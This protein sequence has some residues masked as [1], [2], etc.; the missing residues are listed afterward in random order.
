MA[1]VASSIQL[2]VVLSI[3]TIICHGAELALAG[4]APTILEDLSGLAGQEVSVPCSVDVAT[5][6]DFHSVKWYRESQRV[7]VY[8]EL[9]NLERSEGSLT[10]R[11]R[12]VLSSNETQAGL[13]ISSLHLADEGLY[14][15]EITYL[16]INEGCPVVQY[17]NLTVLAAPEYVEI[18]LEDG[19][20]SAAIRNVSRI[21]PFNEDTIVTLLCRSGGGRPVPR[22]EWWNGSHTLEGELVA[23]QEE[24]GAMTGIN[25]LQVVLTRQD[26]NAQWQCRVNSPALHS[27]LVANLRIDVHVKPANVT[28]TGLDTAVTEGTA[29]V[30]YCVAEGARPAATITWY[31]DSSPLQKSAVET[32]QLQ[33]DGTF[34]TKSRLIFTLN[35]HDHRRYITC[36]AG[37]T[38]TDDLH[39]KPVQ[40]SQLLRVE[41][42]PMVAVSPENVTVNET[43]DVLIFCT[44]DANPVTLTSVQWFKD[45]VEI[46]IDGP[47]KYEGATVDQ[48]ALLLK[49][50][51]RDDAGAYSCRLTN[52]VGTGQS[53]NVA[54]ISVQYPAEVRLT[55]EPELPVNELERPNVTLN[56]QVV[57]GYPPVL[58]G[59]RWYLDGELLKELPDCPVNETITAFSMYDEDLCDVDPSKLLLEYV[60]RSFQGNYSCEGMNAAGWGP[61]SDV[62]TLVI[63]YPPGNT[64]LIF[65]PDVV[66]KDEPMT[67][68][69]GVSDVGQ[70]AV[71]QY[72]WT[73]NGHVIPEISDAQ[74]N[75]SQVTLNYQAN[76]SCTPVN[77]AGEGETATVEVEVYAGPTF[78]ERL[79]PTSGALSDAADATKLSCRVECY[80]LCQIDWFRNGLP[81]RE[82]PMYTIVDSFVP[83]NVKFNQHQSVKS[84]L[85]FNMRMWSQAKLDPIV[86]T[87]NYTCTST[88]NVVGDGVSSTTFFTVEY[89][90]TN[91]VIDRPTIEV[92]EG[93]I[94]GHL[95]CSAS[96]YPLA[97]YYWQYNHQIIGNG[98][99]LALDYGLSR[100]KTGEYSCVAHNQHG[101][102]SAKAFI[103]VVY[104]PEC[105]ITLREMEGKTRLICEVKANPKLVDF[106]WMLNNSTLTTDIVHMG[107]QSILTID[108]PP[109]VSGVYYCY[110]NN[111][112]GLATPC[113]INVEGGLLAKLGDENI[114]IIA[115]IAAAIVVI[116]VVCI[117]LLVICR[118]QRADDKYNPASS[119]E[120]R[121]NP[122]GGSTM[123]LQPGTVIQQ[124]H[125]HKWPLRPGVQVHVNGTNSLTLAAS[126]S[127]LLS[128]GDQQADASSSNKSRSRSDSTGSL[129]NHPRSDKPADCQAVETG[130]PYYET[131]RDTQKRRGGGDSDSGGG[132]QATDSGSE[133]TRSVIC[134]KGP[135]RPRPL[136]PVESQQ[137][138]VT[139]ADRTNTSAAAVSNQESGTSTRKRKKPDGNLPSSSTPAV[140]ATGPSTKSGNDGL[141]ENSKA[142]YEN[143][144]FH[145]LQTA[146]NKD[147]ASRPSSQMSHTPSSGYGSARST[148]RTISEVVSANDSLSATP[149]GPQGRG[150]NSLLNSLHKPKAADAGL[151]FRS[152]RVPRAVPSS[153]P[154]G[155]NSTEFACQPS[156]NAETITLPLHA[157]TSHEENLQHEQ[158][159]LSIPVPAPRFHTLKRHAYQNMPAPLKNSQVQTSQEHQDNADQ[160]MQTNPLINST[161]STSM[162]DPQLQQQAWTPR[163]LAPVHTSTYDPPK[164]QTHHASSPRFPAFTNHASHQ[165][166]GSIVYA[167]LSIARATPLQPNQ[168]EMSPTEYAVLQFMSGGQEVQV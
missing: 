1:S 17:V 91:T 166:T 152:L 167:D 19:R 74:W 95:E 25:R 2:L 44:Y 129:A 136:I 164:Q 5:C 162:T 12:F 63:Y 134:V 57:N 103:N 76:Y 100:D 42:A 101:N 62:E 161:E 7:F 58:L 143:L 48:P 15:C 146:P 82:S 130:N 98:Q 157:V 75:V 165:P 26:L 127:V 70:P 168:N 68:T 85:S 38:V 159:Q 97:N 6:G 83:E 20:T 144:P 156:E 163:P 36:R 47:H 53:E 89:A 114:I 40:A 145:G 90:P 79:P 116:L 107:L 138:L 11:A 115:I 105:S 9:A 106:T 77:E 113:E 109:P 140:A 81:I 13:K 66:V 119:M 158:Q 55:M 65:E 150:R 14:R 21:G 33:A 49:K 46:I 61:S 137:Q 125:Q 39:Q 41:Y 120:Q 52:A 31:N 118:R 69:C 23:T 22:I 50:A 92:E 147:F 132:I 96:S 149:H 151:R 93:S 99:R 133:S 56:C 154:G 73:R 27:P 51:T 153:A 131:L 110:V 24:S 123:T 45:D 142:F 128:P 84:T 122:E 10:N 117:V 28:L 72:R 160:F 112:V 148:N 60:G 80:P 104:K 78:I 86:D 18:L 4:N 29:V 87:A 54:F 135:C 141:P 59:V 94:A 67:L 34:S 124:V 102:S 71:T 3:Q 64:T 32:T 8:S 155:N 30:V 43:M 111:S 108:G 126:G 121:E 35:R 16:E 37:N 139:E 88:D